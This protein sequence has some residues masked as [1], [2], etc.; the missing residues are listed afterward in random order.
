MVTAP[1]FPHLLPN[2]IAGEARP[3]R[4]G[5]TIEKRSPHSGEVQF[6][7]ARSGKQDVAAAVE[8]AEQ[9]QPAW[10]D[11]TPV[12]RGAILHDIV[13]ALRKRSDD[14]ARIVA[15]ETGKSFK[16]A[17]GETEGAASLGAF[18]AGEGQ[19]LY[20]RTTT[21]GVP[22]RLVFHVRE[23]IGVAGLIIAANTPVAN[24]AWKVF[25]ALIC[26]NTAVLKSAEDTPATAW[27]FGEIA[28][29]AGLP[30]GVLNIVHGL[31]EEAGAALT[32]HPGVGVI[33]FTGS[34]YVGKLVH[35][36]AGKRLAR[37]SL[38]LGGKNALLVCDDADLENAAKWVLLSAFS[39]AGQRCAAA[40]RVLVF[41]GIYD[42]FRDLLLRGIAKLRVGPSDEDDFGPVINRE[43]RDNMIQSI[44][45]AK[46][47]GSTV[48]AGG[49]PLSGEGRE[50]GCYMAPTLLENAGPG[51]DIWREELFGPIAILHRVE[52]YKE[53]LTLVN[54]SDYGLTAAIHTR[55]LNR[56]MEFARRI[57]TGVVSINGGTYGSEP[58]LPFGGAKLSGNGS[59]EPGTEA[60]E[61]YSELKNIML[62]FDPSRTET[63]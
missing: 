11:V 28:R 35:A 27:I 45:R 40:S 22:N 36:A 13:Q 54:D 6:A 60:L 39:N 24:V 26:G 30:A 17:K 9:A 3:A 38:E 57:K 21:S 42:R 58:H 61:V 44:E 32:A 14:V 59:R 33:S 16:D 46:Q 15:A 41:A 48:A 8:A 53:A 50:K 52:S 63:L 20:G 37:V 19:R 4:D 29:E 56:A 7:F 34:S 49:E 25:P 55:D 2:L 18:Y 1:M 10:A 51:T 31:G 23:P 47:Q 5:R 12:K 43:Q 62:N